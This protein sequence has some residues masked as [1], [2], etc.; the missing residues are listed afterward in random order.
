MHIHLPMEDEYAW[1]M[2]DIYEGGFDE[3]IKYFPPL[4]QFTE[5]THIC[6][7]L[8]LEPFESVTKYKIKKITNQKKN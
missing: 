4:S 2:S 3:D 8:F 7:I 6:S 1:N 5:P